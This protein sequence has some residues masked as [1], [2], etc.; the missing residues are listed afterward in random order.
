MANEQPLTLDLTRGI[1]TTKSA[2]QDG[3]L[4]IR[5][6]LNFRVAKDGLGGLEQTPYFSQEYYST[7]GM[8]YRYSGA[9]YGG[10]DFPTGFSQ[11]PATGG[12]LVPGYL[13]FT[14]DCAAHGTSRLSLAQ[15]QIF[16][17]L[18]FPATETIYTSIHLEVV[19][20]A[21][22]AVT[23]G[24]NLDV[25][26]TGAAAFRWRKNGGGWTAGVPSTA[27]VSIDGGNAIL[28]FLAS[29]G[30]AG[31]EAWSW[32]RTDSMHPYGNSATGGN[33]P[34]V[35]VL[36]GGSVFF[37][38]HE[39]ALYEFRNGTIT[40]GGYYPIYAYFMTVFEKHLILFGATA[41]R[42]TSFNSTDYPNA[43]VKTS[44]LNDYNCFF[45]TDVNEADTYDVNEDADELQ[46]AVGVAVMQN[47]LFLITNRTIYYTDYLGLPAVYSFTFFDQWAGDGRKAY[48]LQVTAGRTGVILQTINSFIHFDGSTFE[49][50]GQKLSGI[51]GTAFT[52]TGS[53]PW[54]GYYNAKDDEYIFANIQPVNNGNWFCWQARYG[55]WY[56]RNPGVGSTSV[57]CIFYDPIVYALYV[58]TA[59]ASAYVESNTPLA[60][61]GTSSS[62][63]EPYIITSPVV[64]P[65][66]FVYELS[67]VF[68]TPKV[69]SRSATYFTTTTSLILNIGWY[70][71]IDGTYPT[72]TTDANA[73]WN[74]SKT[75]RLVSYPRVSGRRIALRILLS[76]TGGKPPY[77]CDIYNIETEI[78][79]AKATR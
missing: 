41:T 25:E 70:D 59:N 43:V 69:T 2:I 11:I 72:V 31:T 4:G 67:T 29:T 14:F 55:T 48:D 5:D 34:T 65:E 27:G 53:M 15:T 71:I 79:Q 44:D 16:S 66:G 64:T 68:V 18:T 74:S 38:N 26:M 20:S 10:S 56:R 45:S 40:Q 75:S 17:L 78:R 1:D 42:P 47:R 33:R 19:S 77:Q 50:I 21:G 3:S 76:G 12:S 46:Y 51:V 24:N 36:V 23:L 58:G 62:T 30:F 73:T 37:L 49:D 7:S 63:I 22:L 54:Y 13:K 60:A 8:T 57:Y 28:Y 32:M 35:S 6:M 9:T 61:L 39:R 52:A